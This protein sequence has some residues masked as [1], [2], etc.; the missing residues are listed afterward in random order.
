VSLILPL[1]ADSRARRLVQ[2]YGGLALYGLSA[3]LLVEA[4]LG[5]D[6]W[7]VL[8]QGI[9]KRTGISIGVSTIAISIVVLFLWIPLRQRPGLGTLS[10]AILIGVWI[11]VS[12][13]LLPRPGTI[14]FRVS[15]LI[16]GILA[17]GIAT[18]LYIGAGLG[19]GPRDGLMTGLAA[20]GRSIRVVRTA[21]EVAVLALGF[22][23]GGSV[24]IGT[25]AY[26][27]AI[28]PLAHVTIPLFT[29][30]GA[31]PA[32]PPEAHASIA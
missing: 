22:V 14:L 29:V 5:L 32:S 31:D 3:A 25:V 26:A 6:P 11:D 16:V 13:F 10:N 19:P 15:F 1:P 28:G 17:N 30:G 4:H 7:D 20:R 18:G 2:L 12:L 24:G 8:H 21:I 27:L 9:A 23:M